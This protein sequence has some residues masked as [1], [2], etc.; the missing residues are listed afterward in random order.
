MTYRYLPH[1]YQ[2]AANEVRIM[3]AI[4][5]VCIV[6]PHDHEPDEKL[7]NGK[8]YDKLWFVNNFRIPAEFC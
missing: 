1:A 7:T 6:D 3:F 4:K 2:T 8:L 5:I